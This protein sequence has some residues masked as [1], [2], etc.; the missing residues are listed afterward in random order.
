[1]ISVKKILTIILLLL[2][3]L[4]F[5]EADGPDYFQLSIDEPVKLYADSRVDAEVILELT[6][7]TNGL[8]NKGCV[9]QPGYEVWL[10]MNEVER[11]DARDSIWCKVEYQQLAG[12]IQQKY[13]SEGSFP[14]P[15]FSCQMAAGEVEQRICREPEL[16][17]FDN[18]LY[19]VYH[20]AMEKAG[21]I[22][23]F[24]EEAVNTLKATQRGWIKGRNECW[25]MPEEI[26]RCI[27]EQYEY[28]IAELQVKWM[29]VD[30]IETQRFTC[31]RQ[32]HEFFITFYDSDTLPAAAVEYGDNR[33]VFVGMPT[34][35]G[36]R[37]NGQFGRY[38]W[39]KNTEAMF[40]W[41]QSIEP[42]RCEYAKINNT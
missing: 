25:K 40:V 23:A 13:L 6:G 10:Q 26:Q 15:S 42:L 29:L 19:R 17:A 20:S 41:D 7:K 9:G 35:S 18:Q 16:I 27:S 32:A 4:L 22:D 8:R 30:S 12:W 5:A 37:Y 39:V 28:R 33:E 31:G 2:P 3:R 34:A 38:V 36:A 1:M 21:S 14:T 11:V 24:A